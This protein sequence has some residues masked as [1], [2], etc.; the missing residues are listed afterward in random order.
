MNR[1]TI[2]RPATREYLR[3]YKNDKYGPHC[4]WSYDNSVLFQF[5]TYN[6][7]QTA[8]RAISTAD[9]L[10]MIIETSQ[11]KGRTTID[12]EDAS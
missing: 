12:W 10:K 9:H 8:A 3:F 7:A 1:Y 6:Q 5:H 11:V 4:V 2:Y